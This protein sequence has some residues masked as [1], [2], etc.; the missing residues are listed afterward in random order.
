MFIFSVKKYF[1]TAILFISWELNAQVALPTFQGLQ[2]I[3]YPGPGSQTF[4]YTGSQ[5]T[6]TVPSGVNTITIKVWGAQ[7][8]DASN[9]DGGRGGYATG[10]LSVFSGNTIYV[11]VGGQGSVVTAAYTAMGG[12]WNGGGDGRANSSYNNNVGGG[13]GASDVRSGGTALSNRVIVGGGGGGANKNSQSY[14]GY[15]GGLTGSDG[16]SGY[17]QYPA[18]TGG[19][20]ST[21]GSLYGA[22]G[23]GGNATSSLTPWNGGGGGGWYGGG[24]AQAHTGGGGG[25]GYIGGVSSSETIAG[26]A[27]MPNPDGGTMT[28][29]EGN[30]LV[31]I[32][33]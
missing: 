30:G 16:G 28:G 20:Q 23:I 19:T 24:V 9:N 10:T 13:G 5:Q 4:S 21:G 18:G 14:G 11:Y 12:G 27:T 1:I 17:A 15:G 3:S 33:W 26:N 22:F 31:V 7:G 32:S 6:F 29:R 2:V 25:S 8:W